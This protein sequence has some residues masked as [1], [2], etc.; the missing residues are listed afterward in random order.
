MKN[1]TQQI[2]WIFLYSIMVIILLL[3]FSCKSRKTEKDY[4]KTANHLE[5]SAKVIKSEMKTDTA[6]W[7]ANIDTKEVTQSDNTFDT[8]ETT[9]ISYDSLGRIN[10][11]TIDKKSKG[12]NKSNSNKTDNSVLKLDYVKS[13]IKTTDSTGIKSN[14]IKEIKKNKITDAKMNWMQIGVGF[15]V[16]ILIVFAGIMVFKRVTKR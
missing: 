2:T 5:Q 13:E 15:G 16:L 12:Q 9:V 10:N 4:A 11:V 3:M 6:E 1:P 7:K 14:D 8:E